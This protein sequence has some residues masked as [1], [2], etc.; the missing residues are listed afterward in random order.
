MS[1]STLQGVTVNSSPDIHHSDKL[2]FKKS[3]LLF[4]IMSKVLHP[5]EHKIIKTLK[6]TP[7]ITYDEIAKNT[8]LAID[9]VRRGVEWLKYKINP[10]LSLLKKDLILFS[11]IQ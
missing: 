8:Q 11:L 5:I 6:E 1:P 3:F 7:N 9:Q 2:R 4:V 10:H